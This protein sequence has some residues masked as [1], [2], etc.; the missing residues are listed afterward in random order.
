MCVND[1]RPTMGTA[2]VG[3]IFG[4]S[5]TTVSRWCRE[6]REEKK[7]LPNAYQREEGCPWSIP[8]EDVEALKR[9]MGIQ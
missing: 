3:E 6:K 8:V 2:E 7:K 9:K 1:E 4:V 5:K